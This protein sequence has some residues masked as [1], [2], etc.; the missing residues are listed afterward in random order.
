MPETRVLQAS[1]R[2]A[3]LAMLIQNYA[4]SDTKLCLDGPL[5]LISQSGD[6]GEAKGVIVKD[7]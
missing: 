7:K 6:H 5:F 2:E 4:K 1:V 3:C